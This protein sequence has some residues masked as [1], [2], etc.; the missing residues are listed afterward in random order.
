MTRIP[1]LH[2]A[3]ERTQRV[4]D[5]DRLWLSVGA[6]YKWNDKLAF[7]FAYSH[8]FG[9]GDDAID[10]RR[11]E[12]VGEQAPRALLQRAGGR[13]VPA[14]VLAMSADGFAATLAEWRGWLHG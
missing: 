9:I 3:V 8:I 14:N 1:P 7:D 4:P 13:E 2:S 10:R 6:T 5:T 12:P 11:G